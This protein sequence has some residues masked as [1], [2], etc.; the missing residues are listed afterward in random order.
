MARRTDGRT[1]R[2]ILGLWVVGALLA[3]VVV[4]GGAQPAAACICVPF[5][6]ELVAEADVVFTGSLDPP[7]RTDDRLQPY[8]FE[9]DQVFKGEAHARQWVVADDYGCGTPFDTPGSYLVLAEGERSGVDDATAIA[10]VLY[11]NDCLGTELLDGGVPDRLDLGPPQDPVPGTSPAPPP[12][13][14]GT[15][16]WVLLSGVAAGVGLIAAGLA[17]VTGLVRRRRAPAAG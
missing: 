2:R 17:G 15:S 13:P 16:A 5:G 14:R 11:T 10:G 12:V 4:L 3:A 7:R 1:S 8:L 9:V 6:S